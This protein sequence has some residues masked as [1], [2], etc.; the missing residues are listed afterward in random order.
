MIWGTY[1][2]GRDTTESYRNLDVRRWQR[3]KLLTAGSFFGWQWSHEGEVLAS[4]GVR[5]ET[6]RVILS[7]RHRFNEEPWQDVEYPVL[8]EWTPCEFGG[9]RAWFLC[10]ARGCGR[11]VAILYSGTIFFACRHCHQLQYQSQER[12]VWQRAMSRVRK[13]RVK[14]GGLITERSRWL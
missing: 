12:R 2:G 3:D 8:I 6:S 10:P 1:C 13:I 14:L 7:Y 4:I 11:R 9:S 5:A